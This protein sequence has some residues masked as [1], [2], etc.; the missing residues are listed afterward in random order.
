MPEPAPEDT[1]G[2]FFLEVGILSQLSRAMFE[3]RLPPG[4]AL[5]HFTV[6][7]HLVRVKDGR[8]PLTWRGRFRCQRP[9]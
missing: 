8:T 4:F 5:P 9:A 3:A 7:N 1:Y 2:A 6:L